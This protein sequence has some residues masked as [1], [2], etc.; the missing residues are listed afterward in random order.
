MTSYVG[1]SFGDS[2]ILSV[3]ELQYKESVL[4]VVGFICSIQLLLNDC[5]EIGTVMGRGCDN[6]WRTRDELICMYTLRCFVR[7]CD[8]NVA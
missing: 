2:G 4:E 3:L 5:A 1:I 7:F 6:T 8:S